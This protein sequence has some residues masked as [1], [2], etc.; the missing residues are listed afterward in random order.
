MTNTLTQNQARAR[1]IAW[2]LMICAAMVFLMVIL[3][4]ATRLTESGLS[5]VHWKPLH[6]LP[7]LSEAEWAEEFAAYQQFPEFQKKNTWMSV[8][9]FKRIF[10]LEYIH[11]LW[12]RTIGVVF[13]VPF[14]VFLWRGWVDRPLAWKLAGLFA[15]GGA[16]GVLGWYMVA[17]GLVDR[18]DVSQYRLAAHLVTAFVCFGL[19][20]WVA[21]DLFR[22]AAGRNP[23]DVE[24]QPA[25]RWSL[26]TTLFALL[27]VTSGA[28]VA[29]LDAGKGFNTF[30]LMDGQLIPAGLYAESPW[31][32][33]WFENH[34]TVQFNHRVLAMILAIF[35]ALL[36]LKTRA[37]TLAPDARLAMNALLAMVF[38]Q[39]G[40]GIL[41][42][43]YV[44]PLALALAHQTGAQIVFALAVAVTHGLWSP[45]TQV[46]AGTRGLHMKPAE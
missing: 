9:D 32:L 24:T 39:A 45:R 3:G 18:P 21:L 5:M 2:W 29:G 28:F 25:G 30:P 17:S 35:I 4:G 33:N 43:L 12:G 34:M 14:V 16:Q 1:I 7:P 46:A 11:R 15:L 41:T 36:W 44:V 38:V 10:W 19:I 40:L 26:G 8:D 22:F 20:L 13:F 42:L 6:I 31:Y 23:P 37:L 27:V